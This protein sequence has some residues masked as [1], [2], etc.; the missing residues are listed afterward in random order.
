MSTRH[1]PAVRRGSTDS[2]ESLEWSP[3]CELVDRRL[4]NRLSRLE[5]SAVRKNQRRDQAWRMCPTPVCSE[6]RPDAA[7]H[8]DGPVDSKCRVEQED[9]RSIRNCSPTGRHRRYETDTA[10]WHTVTHYE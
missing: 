3:T 10:W 4:K 7:R 8:K 9:R 1:S 6:S 5:T 2:R